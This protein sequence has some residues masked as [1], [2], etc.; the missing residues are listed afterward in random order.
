[1]GL[2]DQTLPQKVHL[3][4]FIPP[5]LQRTLAMPHS[6]PTRELHFAQQL[7]Q[8][9][10]NGSKEAPVFSYAQLQGDNPLLPCALITHYPHFKALPVLTVNQPPAL[11]EY[12]ESYQIPLTA[13][14]QLSGGTALL[15]NQAKCPFKAFAHYRLMAK[16]LPELSEGI[17]NKDKGLLA[18]RCSNCLG[19]R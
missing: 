8:R 15:G 11:V 3:S 14:E 2:S 13:T 19:G 10:N 18:I 5:P 12:D 4:A 1:M 17:D 6:N 16:P 7:L 9:L